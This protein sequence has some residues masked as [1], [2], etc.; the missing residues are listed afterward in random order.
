MF[1]VW[2]VANGNERSFF[3]DQQTAKDKADWLYDH[4]FDGIPFIHQHKFENVD[5]LVEFLN[6]GCNSKVTGS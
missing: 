5:Q 6:N 1:E 3:H 2:E 4:E